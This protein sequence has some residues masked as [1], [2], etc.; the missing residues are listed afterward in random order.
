MV[1]A[2][3][4]GEEKRSSSFG[5]ALICVVSK[6]CVLASHIFDDSRAP[7]GVSPIRV[8]HEIVAW[9]DVTHPTDHMVQK[10][11]GHQTNEQY[12]EAGM[13][14]GHNDGYRESRVRS[15]RNASGRA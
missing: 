7:E 5:L 1:G 11:N 10:E 14:R 4:R 3:E 13:E 12:R 2:E 9:G 6:R 15:A 8:K